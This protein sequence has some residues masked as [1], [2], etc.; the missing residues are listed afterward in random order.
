MIKKAGAHAIIRTRAV[1]GASGDCIL[2]LRRGFTAPV[3]PGLWSLPGGVIDKGETAK[4]AMIRECAEEIGLVDWYAFSY[5]G[6][7]TIKVP[8]HPVSY[9]VITMQYLPMIMLDRS[10]ENIGFMWATE[11]DT[12]QLPIRV[13]DAEAIQQF[14]RLSHNV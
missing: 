9:F 10:F 1:P 14:W 5:K 2:L 6:F 7:P 8:E 12:K 4:Q 3:A 13:E 11:E